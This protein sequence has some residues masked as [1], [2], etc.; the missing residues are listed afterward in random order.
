M[1]RIVNGWTDVWTWVN[2]NA[3]VAGLLATV[4]GGLAVAAIL[5][6]L[7]FV[8]K[9][10]PRAQRISRWLWAW[11]PLTHRRFERERARILDN[12]RGYTDLRIAA[13]ADAL[14]EGMLELR[15][16]VRE[17]E[18]DRA[19]LKQRLEEPQTSASLPTPITPRLAPRWRLQFHGGDLLYDHT[20][21][22][23][24]LVPGSAAYRVRLENAPKSGGRFEFKSAAAW[25]DL[26]GEREVTFVGEITHT[27][28]D[29]HFSLQLEWFDE[30]DN[31]ASQVFPLPGPKELDGLSQDDTTTWRPP[32]RAS[33]PSST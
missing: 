25:T 11:R 19:A 31:Y 24:N 2:A 12:A 8:P 23:A 32:T 1:F 13:V 22:L 9:I 20:Y 28:E 17:L 30:Y 18:K 27:N 26:S 4:V 14:G 6:L 29:N 21:V 33:P 10:G 16:K 15:P 3:L 5:K 7:S